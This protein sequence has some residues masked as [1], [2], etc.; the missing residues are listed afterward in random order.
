LKPG[1]KPAVLAWF[2]C[3]AAAAP[4]F[5]APVFEKSGAL[6]LK[7]SGFLDQRMT[8]IL[9]ADSEPEQS[10]MNSRI[11]I[12][13]DRMRMD[14]GQDD[15]GFVLFDRAARTVWHV[16]PQDRKVTGIVAGVVGLL[17]P[18]LGSRPGQEHRQTS[19]PKDWKLT[20][21]EMPSEQNL[22]TQLRLNQT[23]CVEFKSA[24]MLAWQSQL[25]AEFRQTLASNQARLWQALPEKERQP[26]ALAVNVERAGIEYRRGLPL[27]IR[28]WDGRSRV[29]LAHQYLPPR[30]QLFELPKQFR[31]VLIGAPDQAKE[32]R[33]QPRSSQAR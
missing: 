24:P 10:R 25:L 32:S 31:Q 30:P 29:Y 4:V 23:L 2:V 15:Q 16:S 13:G 1:C 27:A 28:Y 11:L 33:R 17:E 12:L 26:C 22:L 7:L 3:C 14:F 21:D 19:W 6:Q 9:Y 18:K 20:Q 8:E 5:A